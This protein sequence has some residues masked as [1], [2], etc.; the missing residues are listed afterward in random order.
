LSGLSVPLYRRD[1]VLRAL[2]GATQ[3]MRKY[4][5]DGDRP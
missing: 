5:P 3:A 4:Q 1:R 2:G